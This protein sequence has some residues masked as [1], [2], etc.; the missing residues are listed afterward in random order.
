MNK[1]ELMLDLKN[2]FKHHPPRNEEEI[3]QHE[4]VRKLCLGLALELVTICP[5]SR[6]LSLALTHLE[7]V[8]FFANGALARHKED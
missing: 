2:R 4:Q 6:K 3:Q 7:E 1:A 8:M 5:V